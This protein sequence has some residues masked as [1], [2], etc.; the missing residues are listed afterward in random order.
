MRWIRGIGWCAFALLTVAIG[1]QFLLAC[2]FRLLGFERNA[3]VTPADFTAHRT[4]FQEHESLLRQVHTAE[5]QIAEKPL[6]TPVDPVRPPDASQKR[7]Y[8]RGAKR[9]KL[10]VFLDWNTLD[11]VDL[12]V[13]CPG[14]LI[15]SIGGKP[16]PGV[17]GDGKLDLDAN[18][19]LRNNVVPNPVEHIVWQEDIPSGEYVFQAGLFKPKESGLERNI[20]FRMRIRFGDDERVCT[21]AIPSYPRSQNRR[22]ASGNFLHSKRLALRWA[23]GQPLPECNWEYNDVTFCAPG[24]CNKE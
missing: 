5:L 1:L 4:A 11:D 10:E 23:Y 16:G 7:A 14:G 18:G 13:Q 21:G 8:D 12:S 19:N 3:C 6:C 24:E 17:C 15:S 20:P 2:E 9:G 22:S